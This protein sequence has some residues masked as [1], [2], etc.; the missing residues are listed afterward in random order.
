[1]QSHHVP[2]IHIYSAMPSFEGPNHELIASTFGSRILQL[3]SN[4]SKD[5]EHRI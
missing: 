1:M 4:E 5:I 2:D 3:L